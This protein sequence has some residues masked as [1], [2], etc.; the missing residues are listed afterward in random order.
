MVAALALSFGG[1]G[2]D[3]DEAPVYPED[4]IDP[5]QI[6]AVVEL[7]NVAA[8]N[9]DA[10]LL[11]A[12]VV[13][14]SAR[15]GSSAACAERVQPAMDDEPENWQQIATISTIKVTGDSATLKGTQ[16]GGPIE[17]DFVREQGRWWM[18]VAD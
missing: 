14:P 7:F 16:G 5:E 3:A 1:C 15:G 8:E 6:A 10:G 9:L 18:V 13:P 12:E 2:S 4:G 17:L 11:C